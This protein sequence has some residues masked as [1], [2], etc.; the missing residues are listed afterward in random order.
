MPNVDERIGN[1]AIV[2]PL[3]PPTF[4]LKTQTSDDI[5]GGIKLRFGRFLLQSSVYRMN[6]ENELHLSPI[7]FANINLD[8]TRR[9]GVETLMT[10]GVTDWLRLKANVDLSAGVCSGK[11]RS[12]V[13][14]CRWCR[15]GPAM[16]ECRWISGRNT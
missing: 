6:L 8:P 12:R 14:S 3:P 7:T 2:F 4:A 1:G 11:G 15:A 5:E 9:S 16:P 13:I 10:W